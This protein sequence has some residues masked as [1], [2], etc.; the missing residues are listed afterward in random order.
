[1]SVTEHTVAFVMLTIASFSGCSWCFCSSGWNT[2]EC[3]LISL[4][5][6]NPT[7]LWRPFYSLCR[8]E[9]VFVGQLLHIGRRIPMIAQTLCGQTFALANFLLLASGKWL[10]FFQLIFQLNIKVLLSPFRSAMCSVHTPS[11]WAFLCVSGRTLGSGAFGRVVEATAY[12]L[13]HSQSSIKVAVK[14]LKCKTIKRK[15]QS[16]HVEL[17]NTV[18]SEPCSCENWE[19]AEL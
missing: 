10:F 13:S 1:M 11:Y 2:K 15:T 8:W 18:A 14:M 7:L 5:G 6:S 16:T 4:L 17:S 3:L 12:G 9:C 19:P